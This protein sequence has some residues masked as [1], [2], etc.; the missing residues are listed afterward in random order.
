MSTAFPFA[1]PVYVMLKPVGAQCNLACAYCYY[2]EKAKLV[3]DGSGQLMSEELLETFT[4]FLALYVVNACNANSST[5]S[6]KY[7]IS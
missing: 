5:Y 4:N 2:L 1:K 3:H 7:N 6:V